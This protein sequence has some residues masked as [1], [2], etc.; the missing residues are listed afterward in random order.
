MK[1]YIAEIVNLEDKDVEYTTETYSTKEEAIAYVL[2][3]CDD[4]FGLD[5]IV[6][7]INTEKHSY[8]E[9]IESTEVVFST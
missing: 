8:K 5:G 3:T 4:R 7:E 6:I 9:M 1:F 2:E